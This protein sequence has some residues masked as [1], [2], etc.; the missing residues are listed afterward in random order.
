MQWNY[1]IIR[2]VDSYKRESYRIHEVY[3]QGDKIST[4]SEVP[5]T[6]SG[7]DVSELKED[8]RRMQEAFDKPILNY[9]EI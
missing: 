2:F 9:D 4:V 3:Y 1:R 6:P 8:I 5:I 7:E